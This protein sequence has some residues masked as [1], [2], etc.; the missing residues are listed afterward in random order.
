ME[1]WI[2]IDVS[3]ET[4][5]FAL[6]DSEGAQLESAQ[7]ANN[8]RA[9]LKLVGQWRK[10]HGV[11]PHKSLFCLEP[12]GHYTR[13]MLKLVVEQHWPTWLAHPVDIQKSM[14]MN[15]AKTDKVDALRIARYAR[16]FSEKARLFTAD[17]LR[18]DEL[19]HLLSRRRHLVRTRA[20]YKAHMADLNRFMDQDIKGVFDRMDKR[21]MKV[22][23]K[24]VE[25]V[26]RLIAERIA[27]D[28]KTQRQYDLLRSIP[29]IGP[30]LAAHLL[31]ITDGFVRF[32]D[33]RELA[34]QAGVVP[35]ERSS[36]SSVRGR[37]HV[38]YQANRTLKC[39]LHMAA[40]SAVQREGEL[41]NYY[42]RKVAAGKNRMS[43]MNA[44]RNKLVHRA[45]SVIRRDEPYTAL[46]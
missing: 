36:G 13:P 9:V 26:D 6:L 3:S 41:K 30:Q 31:A 5:D 32:S 35:F 19:K 39:L 7:V 10:H 17:H 37:A 33:P 4:L 21:Q 1:H 16:T 22:L 20:K 34:C 38:S 24:L 46:R 40:M 15:R 18:L 11:D 45:C 28:P 23:D 14:G 25:E 27:A 44:V 29:G 43:V 12:T 42:D 8:S 2:G